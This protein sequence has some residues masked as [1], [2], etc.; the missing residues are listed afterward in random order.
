[1]TA[2]T[3]NST[4]VNPRHAPRIVFM[5]AIIR[6]FPPRNKPRGRGGHF[7]PGHR[8]RAGSSSDYRPVRLNTPSWF[9]VMTTPSTSPVLPVARIV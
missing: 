7:Q 8:P 5:V 2:T 6:Q 4:S 1:M 3:I 9:S